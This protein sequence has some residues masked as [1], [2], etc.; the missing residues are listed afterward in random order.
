MKNF[1]LSVSAK[2]SIICG[3]LV[4]IFLSLNTYIS[5]YQ[6]S[7][8][9][10]FIF[11]EYVHKVEQT[12]D[13]Q[14]V[15]LKSSLRERVKIVSSICANASASFLYNIDSKSMK[16]V[17]TSYMG[18]QGI[19]AIEV[20]DETDEPFMAIWREKELKEARALPETLIID[21]EMFHGSNSIYEKQK[22]GSVKVYYTEDL[23]ERHMKREKKKS[24]NDID[25]FRKKVDSRFQKASIYQI[26]IAV[27]IIIILV[28]AIMKSL[29]YTMTK[30]LYK[31]KVMVMDLVEG[32]GDLTKRLRVTTKDEIGELAEWFNK[33]IEIMQ[34]L[35]KDFG[36]N[37]HTL[38][39]SSATM[40][41]I[42]DLMA[43]NSQSVSDKATTVAAATE[44]MSS[45]MTMVSNASEQTTTNVT[46]V[47][48]STEEMNV[49]FNEITANSEKARQVTLDAVGK[50]QSASERVNEL[51][52]AAAEISKVTEVITEISEQ[53]NLLA[54]N[55]TIEAARAG[56]A[57]KGFAVV[58]NEIKELAKQTA[59]ATLDIKNKI[60]GIQNSTDGT[61]TEIGEITQVI[62]EV[63]DSVTIIAT[64]VKEQ[65]VATRE[66]SQNVSQAS[67]G[68][69]EVHESVSQSS[70]VAG[71]IASDISDVTASAEEMAASCS[72][73]NDSSAQLSELAEQLND[74][75]DKFK[76]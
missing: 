3:F 24:K 66:I 12:I 41:E 5:Y 15:T 75:V 76:V 21:K 18:F 53:T 36:G 45:N 49:T 13:D 63:N 8:L 42:A 11:D 16:M 6:S 35:I 50:A 33:F 62:N 20:F 34:N 52:S 19:T 68:I 2:T 71:E 23:I 43:E 14:G 48:A 39:T 58:A 9:V 73:V 30:P 40:S 69:Q 38:R 27:G 64:A 59:D 26:A 60:S 47:A 57:G 28:V 17:L 22:I 7:S 25:V 56:E 37:V 10:S 46:M 74:K 61:V 44:E 51:G 1:N 29:F 54:L 65:D 4:L 55:A 72:Q 32:D 67:Q 31:L 70:S